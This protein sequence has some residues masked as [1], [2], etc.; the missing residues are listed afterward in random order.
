MWL[1]SMD[2]FLESLLKMSALE[3]DCYHE[4]SHMIFCAFLLTMFV[5]RLWV[6]PPSYVYGVL[7]MLFSICSVF[8][9]NANAQNLLVWYTMCACFYLIVQCSEWEWKRKPSLEK[10]L[11][12]S[13]LAAHVT[14]TPVPSVSAN[15]LLETILQT[16]I[17]IMWFVW[18]CKAYTCSS[19]SYLCYNTVLP[20]GE[21]KILISTVQFYKT[22]ASKGKSSSPFKYS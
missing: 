8:L 10:N 1:K 20:S 7:T 3:F 18:T 17:L 2:G 6:S 11:C 19:L 22:L 16:V 14:R 15:K 21:L 13:E 4:W 5:G 12:C 9:W